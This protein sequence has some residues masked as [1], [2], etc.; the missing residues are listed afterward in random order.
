MRKSLVILFRIISWI[1]FPPVFIYS[2]FMSNKI[3]EVNKV[4]CSISVL[5]S[6]FT[7]FFII[8]LWG[9]FYFDPSHTIEKMEKNI[10]IEI[11]NDFKL[12]KNNRSYVGATDNYDDVIELLFTEESIQVIAKNIEKTKYFNFNGIKS[13]NQENLNTT[14]YLELKAYLLQS[15]L[16][17]F[18]I[19]K[20][21]NTYV[22]H[23]PNL[24]SLKEFWSTESSWGENA[25]ILFN[26]RWTITAKVFKNEKK[27]E[28]NYSTF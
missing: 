1:I 17:G 26:E 9:Y 23:E 10:G 4:L 25:P 6:P 27:I 15:Q 24:K 18:W 13:L 14:I 12:L 21:S 11:P 19:K 28:Y 8:S 5:F 7:I 16:T 3:K 2:V 20:D 22:F